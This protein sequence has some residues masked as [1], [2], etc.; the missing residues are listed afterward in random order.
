M[1]KTR[2]PQNDPALRR[3]L[4]LCDKLIVLPADK[5]REAIEQLLAEDQRVR[6]E[7]EQILRA[8]DASAGFLSPKSTKVTLG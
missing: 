1:A 6:Q 8:V 7:V 2:C 5:R 4:A 3:A